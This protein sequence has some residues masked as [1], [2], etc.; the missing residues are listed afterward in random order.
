M[1][2]RGA[3]FREGLVLLPAVR[4]FPP[5]RLLRMA[6][7]TKMAVGGVKYLI[8][9]AYRESGEMQ[10]VREL[11]VNAL[12]AGAKR[13]EFGPDWKGVEDD[14]VY[15]LMVADDGKGMSS[16]E[17]L[18]FL[19][20]FGGGGKPIGDA[21]ENYG[22]GAKTSLLPWNR[23]GVVVLS[24]TEGDPAGSM[25]WLMCDPASGEYGARE[26]RTSQGLEAVVVPPPE[27][28]ARR[29]S[30]IQGHGTVVVC[31]GNMGTEDTFLGKDGKGDIKGISAYLNKRIWQIPEDMKVVV[32]ELRTQKKTEWP[33]SYEES[34]APAQEGLPDRRT[35]NR[36]IEGAAR[37]VKTGSTG[38]LAANGTVPLRDGTEVDWYLW[39]GDRPAVHSYAQKGGYIAALYR[40]ELYDVQ[41]HLASFRS[42]AITQ[43]AVRERLT[44]IVRPPPTDGAFGVYPDTARNALKIQGTKRAGEALPWADWGQ[45]FAE[46][47]PQEIRDALAAAGPSSGTGTLSDTR[48]R[49]RLADRFGNRWKT[50]RWLLG[51]GTDKA[52]P[53]KAGRTGLKDEPGVD[54]DRDGVVDPNPDAPV[55]VDVS[56][57]PGDGPQGPE[58]GAPKYGTKSP[59]GA[60]TAK[61]VRAPGGLPSFRWT[62]DDDVE[63]G[64]AAAWCRS[65]PAEP[66]G[67]VVLSRKFP[68]F[69]EVKKYWR[70]QY[71]DHLGPQIDEVVETVYGEAMVARIAHS[72]ALVHDEKWGRQ[73]VEDEL[74]SPEALTMAALGLVSE[75]QVIVSRLAAIVGRRKPR[76]MTAPP[77]QTSA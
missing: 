43:A 9:R 37:F 34:I 60:V 2:A 48:W 19:N 52:V 28:A 27:W 4:T 54:P 44:L 61:R 51:K 72:E 35:N 15:R 65:D 38:K 22:V 40:N 10:Y 67:V 42:F 25:V 11:L 14:G 31:L 29:P 75:D 68:A 20:T 24:W 47:L 41:T 18:K 63:S 58:E 74:R 13:V 66:A 45:E 76:T 23:A 53:E 59:E 12:E 73:R 36:D 50:L 5:V 56:P 64:C 71:A 46:N 3:S 17:L 8:E 32:R 57:S 26:F 77:A 39:E 7:M 30:W 16:E 49:D 21:H 55:S 70:D 1:C 69:V 6:T 33:R 62:A